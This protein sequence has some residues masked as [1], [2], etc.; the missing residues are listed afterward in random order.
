MDP[1][2]T[3][4]LHYLRNFD[5]NSLKSLLDE[6]LA[7]YDSKK[8]L[9]KKPSRTPS[10]NESLKSGIS[11]NTSNNS[12]ADLESSSNQN[13][14]INISNPAI[15][16]LTKNTIKRLHQD[17]TREPSPNKSGSLGVNSTSINLSRPA[18]DNQLT[19][20]QKKR[21]HLANKIQLP[22]KTISAKTDSGNTTPLTGGTPAF[23]LSGNQAGKIQT[24]RQNSEA[25][26]NKLAS[27]WTSSFK[28][29][30]DGETGKTKDKKAKKKKKKADK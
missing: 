5:E 4:A 28:P 3:T 17:K 16:A 9:N 6:Q 20:V 30:N 14:T 13:L 12:A 1:N 21:L 2:L 8:G 26:S 29:E 23:G 11:R 25:N 22:A 10:Q 15:N 24:A 19:E 27:A 7:T 18:N